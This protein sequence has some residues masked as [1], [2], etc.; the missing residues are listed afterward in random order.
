VSI[1][2][3]DFADGRVPFKKDLGL[4]LNEPIDFHRGQGSL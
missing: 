2:V 1:H 3:D 4:V